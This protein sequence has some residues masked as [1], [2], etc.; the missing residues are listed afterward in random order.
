M[1][2]YD[3]C[4]LIDPYSLLGVTINSTPKEVKQAYYNLALLCHPDKGGSSKDMDIV[5]SAYR[6]VIEQIESID[7]ELTFESLEEDFSKFCLEQ[8]KE[9]P[10]TFME[11]YD[12]ITGFNKRF[13][14][15]FEAS[16]NK[17]FGA[18]LP[19]GYGEL[20]EERDNSTDYNVNVEKDNK[21]QLRTHTL[22]YT[23]FFYRFLCLITFNPT[24][25]NCS[26]KN[27][28]SLVE[29]GVYGLTCL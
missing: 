8:E 21:N 10:P 22:T 13:N 9:K 23:H 17:I 11:I 28:S 19:G 29:R 18:T 16:T 25:S 14:E 12:E 26:F 24:S 27:V 15:E 7:F 3:D 20:M 5:N 2:G 6:Y 4:S 1:D